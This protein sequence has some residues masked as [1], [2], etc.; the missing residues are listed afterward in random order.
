MQLSEVSQA[1]VL[2][3]RLGFLFPVKIVYKELVVC[4]KSAVSL[5]NKAQLCCSML[6]RPWGPMSGKMSSDR[7]R[8]F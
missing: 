4:M 8:D 6:D 5:Q 3:R 7:S 2:E 1:V